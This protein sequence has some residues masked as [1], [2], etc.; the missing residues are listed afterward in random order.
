MCGFW[1]VDQTVSSSL[2]G[3]QCATTPRGSIAFGASRWLTMR[4]ETVT[5]AR[6]NA[7]SSAVSSSTSS[8]SGLTPVPA[9]AKG[10]ARLFANA[11]WIVAGS[12][13]IARSGSTTAGSS[14]M[15]TSI[16]AAASAAA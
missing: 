5:A 16:A 13:A 4:C 9:G 1:V 10:T 15:S 2:P 6:A 14:S 7:C 12:P 3:S 8:V 11:S